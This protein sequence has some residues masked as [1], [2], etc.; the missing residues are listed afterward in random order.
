M[1]LTRSKTRDR[2]A[3]ERT[4]NSEPD[5]RQKA[6]ES[7][8]FSL[9]FF[10]RIIVRDLMIILSSWQSN[11][12]GVSKRLPHGVECAGNHEVKEF[13]PC[14]CACYE[15]KTIVGRAGQLDRR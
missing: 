14:V 6:T 1:Q 3:S 4:E 15:S 7:F 2:L 5:D 9:S 11:S 8:L 12:C 10:V 13:D